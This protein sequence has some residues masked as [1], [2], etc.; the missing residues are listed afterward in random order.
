MYTLFNFVN[1]TAPPAPYTD[2]VYVV[3]LGYNIPGYSSC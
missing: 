2:V 1:M 3:Y